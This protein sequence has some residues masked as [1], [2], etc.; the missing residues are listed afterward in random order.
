VTVARKQGDVARNE[1]HSPL[2]RLG[3][4]S[5]NDSHE[6]PGPTRAAI[7]RGRSA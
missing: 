3:L 4:D 2:T 6:Q 7:L 5:N 1:R